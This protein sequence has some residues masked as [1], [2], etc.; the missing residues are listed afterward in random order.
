MFRRLKE[1]KTFREIFTLIGMKP[2]EKASLVVIILWCMIPMMAIMPR[3]VWYFKADNDY[4]FNF[5]LRTSHQYIVEVLGYFTVYIAVFFLISRIAV[6]GKEV[7]KMVKEEPW[8]FFLL[9]M[10]FWACI[11]T[12]LAE[13]VKLAFEGDD[14]LAEGLRLY[15]AYAGIYICSFVIIKQ[16]LKNFVL[17]IVYL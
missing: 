5:V 1:C 16:K 11:S 8:H 9:A 10:L 7:W 14:Y 3:I 12:L 4:Q 17:N 6:Y 15:F 13:D 2:F